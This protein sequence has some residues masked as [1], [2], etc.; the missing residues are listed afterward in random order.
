MA[1]KNYWLIGGIIGII[2]GVFTFAGYLS[3]LAFSWQRIGEFLAF[4][5]FIIVSS[6]EKSLN[7]TFGGAGI[8]FIG[9]FNI[10][11]YMLIGA[12]IGLLYDIVQAPIKDD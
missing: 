3:F 4:F 6:V 10:L 7:I 12:F 11:V 5:G 1:E 9:L 8:Y 2:F